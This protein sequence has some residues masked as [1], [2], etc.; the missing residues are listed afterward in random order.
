MAD[1]LHLLFSGDGESIVNHDSSHIIV[2]VGSR[3]PMNDH[4]ATDTIC[5]LG[6]GVRVIPTSSVLLEEHGVSTRGTWCDGTLSNTRHTI[7]IV[8]SLLGDT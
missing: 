4:R 8:G 3:R 6:K 1:A 7:L 2:I 5:I